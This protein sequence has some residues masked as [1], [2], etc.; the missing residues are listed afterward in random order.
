MKSPVRNVIRSLV[1]ACAAALCLLPT[2]AAAQ[3]LY[4]GVTGIVED[5]SG[6]AVPGATVTITNQETGLEMTAVSDETGT[7]TVR[8]VPGG[9]YTL[10]ASL[11]G[12]KEFVQTGIPITVGN[13]VRINGKLEVGALTESVT[14][15]TE[16]A[17][18][19]TDKADVSVD[20][21]PE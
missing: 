13:I 6:A 16:A 10:K 9:T 5:T 15:T 4:G 12:F 3:T 11:E 21:R 8:N 7:Y 19:K 18:L 1:V 20:L 14:V 2:A 17:L